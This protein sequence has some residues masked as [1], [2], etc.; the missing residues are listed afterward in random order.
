MRTL[1]PRWKSRNLFRHTHALKC[2]Q[3]VEGSALDAAAWLIS[4]CPDRVTAD[5]Y[6]R[7]C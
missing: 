1:L 7:E 2:F 4:P 5:S 6:V 3:A